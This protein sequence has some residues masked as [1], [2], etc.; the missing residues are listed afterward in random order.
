MSNSKH[1][2]V[3]DKSQT[4]R[5]QMIAYIKSLQKHIC[6]E[7]ETLDG[8][9]KKFFADAYTRATGAGMGI[10]SVLSGGKRIEKAGVGVSVVT[11][12]LTP[13]V[14]KQMKANHAEIP[15]TTQSVPFLAAGISLIVH[16]QNPMAPTVHMNYRYFELV[17]SVTEELTSDNVPAPNGPMLAWWFGGGCDLTP[18]YVFEEDAVHFHQTLQ[19]ACAPHGASLYPAFKKW[20]DE[21]F[22]IPH[23]NEGR[24][25]GGI[26]FDDLSAIPHARLPESDGVGARPATP[27]DIFDFVRTCGDAFIPSYIPILHR[28][29]DMP[30]TEEERRWQLLRRGRYVE[31]NLMYDRG[32]KFGLSAPGARIESILMSL[33]ETARWEY[34]TEMGAEGTREGELVALLRTPRDWVP[35]S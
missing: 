2:F 15:E 35:L 24:G 19:D 28:R 29:V 1:D 5:L 12:K 9:D 32:T 27:A 3:P 14:I 10:S 26:F 16:P 20:C 8:G 25:L 6:S 21:Y 17:E 13:A 30:F 18:S 4:M 33:P 11:G 31:F 34:C 22:Y 7:L 23:R